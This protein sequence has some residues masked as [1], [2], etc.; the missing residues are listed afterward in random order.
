MEYKNPT[1]DLVRFRLR[2]QPY[3]V[4]PAGSVEVPNKLAYAVPGVA[5]QLVEATASSANDEGGDEQSGAKPPPKRG[6][7]EASK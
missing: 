5:P 3:E 1:K 7:P 2:G 4:P 6:R